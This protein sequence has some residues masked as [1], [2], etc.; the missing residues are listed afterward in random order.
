MMALIYSRIDIAFD[1]LQNW[2][3]PG[4]LVLLA[5]ILI[6]VLIAFGNAGSQQQAVPRPRL[7]SL[8][9]LP[10]DSWSLAN[11]PSLDAVTPT[12]HDPR[13][14]RSG[15]NLRRALRR[16]GNPVP[17]VVS[18]MSPSATPCEGLVLDRSRGGLLLSVPRATA[19]GTLLTIRAAHAPDD[20][21]WIPIQVRHCRPQED[22]WL[23]GCKFMCELPW[24]VLLLF[25]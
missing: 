20:L 25:G 24:S 8:S 7:P 9:A 2:S 19:A 22:R 16:E 4:T 3:F 14:R 11:K 10:V 5:L 15:R 18:D 23:L 21:A 6:V 12:F 17:V 1:G 13:T